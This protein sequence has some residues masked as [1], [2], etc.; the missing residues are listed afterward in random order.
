MSITVTA[1]AVDGPLFVTVR[2]YVNTSRPATLAGADLLIDRSAS[3]GETLEVAPSVLFEDVCSG[4]EV[5]IEALFIETIDDLK[6]LQPLPELQEGHDV[7]V[8]HFESL[9]EVAYEIDAAIE[10]DDIDGV[11][12]AMASSGDVANASTEAMPSEYCLIAQLALDCG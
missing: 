11:H 2:V 6:A 3:A 7:L 8:N 1:V 12:A 9:L 5:E 10:A 4:V